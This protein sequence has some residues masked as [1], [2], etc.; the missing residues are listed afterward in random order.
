MA[1]PDSHPLLTKRIGGALTVLVAGTGIGLTLMTFSLPIL[2]AVGMS[3]ALL[4]AIGATWIYWGDFRQLRLR[5]VHGNEATQPLYAEQWIVLIAILVAVIIPAYVWIAESWPTLPPDM[6][7]HLREDQQARMRPKLQLSSNQSFSIQINSAPNC[8]ECEVYAQ[9]FRDFIRSVSGWDA[10]GG[11]L[12]YWDPHETPAGL[13]LIPGTKGH[14]EASKMI[15]AAFA[16][17]GIPISER[18]PTDYPDW[19]AV[20]V[21]G[22]RPK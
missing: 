18:A 15:L 21:V 19:D 12:T 22:R 8:D 10:G 5:L 6:S 11:A 13:Q 7:R 2:R 14:P 20:I 3:M 9:D 4:G 17:A 16:V 1:D